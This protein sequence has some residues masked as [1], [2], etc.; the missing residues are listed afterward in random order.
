LTSGS[1]RERERQ[2]GSKR[3]MCLDFAAMHASK[4]FVM[5]N[6][7]QNIKGGVAFPTV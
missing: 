1:Q 3:Q 4:R 5:P 2:F 6:S 7:G